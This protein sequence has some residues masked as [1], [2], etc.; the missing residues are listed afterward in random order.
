MTRMTRALPI[1]LAAESLPPELPQAG[2]PR[3]GTG[4]DSQLVTIGGA[5]LLVIMPLALFLAVS[6]RKKRKRK[7]RLPRNP[8]LAETGGL[9]PRRT[10]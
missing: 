8:T 3:A 9:P 1:I 10:P 6:R 2:L 4:L 5:V 7:V